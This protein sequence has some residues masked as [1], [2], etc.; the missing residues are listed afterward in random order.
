MKT[1]NK[2]Y[3]LISCSVGFLVW[4]CATLLFRVAGQYFFLV[5]NV[6]VMLVLYLML[7]PALGFIATLVFNK[8]RL[9]NPESTKAAA[10]MVLPGML[11]DVVCIQ[12]FEDVFP[13]MPAIYSKTFGA[14]LMFAYAI[15]L[16]FGLLRKKQGNE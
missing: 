2:N 10:I 4:L 14:W 9:G 1:Y 7:V 3:L 5:D 16:V 11:L 13:N 6:M 12:F 8:C 15:V